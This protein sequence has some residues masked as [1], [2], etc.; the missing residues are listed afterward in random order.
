MKCHNNK[1]VEGAEFDVFW[2]GKESKMC[3][4]H[5]KH[6]IKLAKVLGF[7]LSVRP[8]PIPTMENDEP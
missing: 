8:L 2:P 7:N 4:E 6:A 3:N 1:C 5:T